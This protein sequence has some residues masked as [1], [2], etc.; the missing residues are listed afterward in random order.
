MQWIKLFFYMKINKKM[1]S[2]NYV[3]FS[4]EDD[5]LINNSISLPLPKP[6]DDKN[7]D[8]A[9]SCFEDI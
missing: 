7:D 1:E 6:T 9:V 8:G 2:I 3:S 4:T 5:K